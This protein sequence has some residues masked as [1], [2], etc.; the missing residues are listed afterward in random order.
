MGLIKKLVPIMVLSIIMLTHLSQYQLYKMVHH[1]MWM[2]KS[3]MV[4]TSMFIIIIVGI[5]HSY[6]ILMW[7]FRYLIYSVVGAFMM[8]SIC[9]KEYLRIIY[10]GLYFLWSWVEKYWS[11]L[12]QGG[13]SMSIS[14]LGL[15][16]YN[17]Y[18]VQALDF[19]PFLSVYFWGCCHG[20]D[21]TNH[22]HE[23]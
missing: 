7:C 23:W 20:G 21:Q 11:L 16:H 5:L 10:F 12:L 8:N 2:D 22:N 19:W 14:T 18:L 15:C 6:I 4:Y 17:G 13:L 9:S 3:I 1:I